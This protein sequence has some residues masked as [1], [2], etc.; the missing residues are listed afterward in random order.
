MLRGP[1]ETNFKLLNIMIGDNGFKFTWRDGAIMMP[2]R[3]RIRLPWRTT[4]GAAGMPLPKVG[5]GFKEN[6][7][8][9]NR[10]S[11][12]TPKISHVRT[13]IFK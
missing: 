8:G 10:A 3:T 12:H 4:G 6:V 13:Q 7:P 1:L 2:T 9:I 11:G 5:F